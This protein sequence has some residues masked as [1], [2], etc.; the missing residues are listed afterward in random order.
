MSYGY[1]KNYVV[2]ISVF[3]HG[4]N[5]KHLSPNANVKFLL[6]FI[7]ILPN[8]VVSGCCTLDRESLQ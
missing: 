7:E 4:S 2:F 5:S 8:D 1:G 3:V 6:V